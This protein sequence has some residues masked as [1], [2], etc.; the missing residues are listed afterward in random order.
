[1]ATIKTTIAARIRL[2]RGEALV[3][4]EMLKLFNP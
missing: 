3:H 2:R 1:M 4:M